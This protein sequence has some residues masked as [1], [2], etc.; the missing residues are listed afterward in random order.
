MKFN[1]LRIVALFILFVGVG[2]F[3]SCSSLTND[4]QDDDVNTAYVGDWK[5][6]KATFTGE[7]AEASDFA[8]FTI[9]LNSSGTYVLTN[10]S[11]FA[12]PTEA[13]GT[14]SVDGNLLTFTPGAQVA[15]MS[16]SG[17]TMTWE[18]QVAKP[19]KMTATYRY[20]FERI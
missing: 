5:L 11:N 12:S 14:Y 9:A 6:V 10:P 13:V 18:W 19:G 7:V 1:Y 16:M 17:N 3:T 20:T 15:V 8:G 2:A 4:G